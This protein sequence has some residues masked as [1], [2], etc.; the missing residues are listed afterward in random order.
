MEGEVTSPTR[1]SSFRLMKPSMTISAVGRHRQIQRFARRH[2]DIPVDD[3]A[4]HFHLAPQIHVQAGEVAHDLVGRGTPATTAI[5]MRSAPLSRYLWIIRL[6]CG[7]T[8]LTS[9]NPEPIRNS[10]RSHRPRSQNIRQQRN[11]LAR[12]HLI[13]MRSCGTVRGFRHDFGL[14]L[15]HVVQRNRILERRWNQNVAFERQ[16]V[17]V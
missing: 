12:Q 7:V 2:L 6:V 11:A 10:S 4:G 14:D 8:K 5:G 15:I 16:Q 3:G 13:G 17:V 1:N 9:A